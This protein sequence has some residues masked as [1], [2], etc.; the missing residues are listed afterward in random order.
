[1]ISTGAK[2]VVGNAMRNPYYLSFTTVDIFPPYV[3]STSP[4]NG[5]TDVPTNIKI[6]INFS[7]EM[8]WE[9]TGGAVSISPGS[10]REKG[11]FNDETLWF[12]ADLEEGV[13]YTVTISTD[14]M[15]LAGNHMQGEYKF[16]F[17]TTSPTPGGSSV[18]EQVWW[19]LPWIL[20]IV[21]VA[22]L[23]SVIILMRR[24]KPSGKMPSSEPGKPPDAGS[25]TPPSSESGQGPPPPPPPLPPPPPTTS[26]TGSI[27][28]PHANQTL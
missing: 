23:L 8:N 11:W 3:V 25:G 6:T 17:T 24:K 19:A 28:V 21:I 18:P 22:V 14:A 26:A 12:T 5:K 15:D 13:T 16:T 9:V 27:H 4:S 10:I 20:L 7:E 2:D 1:M